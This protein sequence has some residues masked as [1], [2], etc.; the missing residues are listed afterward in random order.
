MSACSELGQSADRSS[1]RSHYAAST[2]HMHVRLSSRQ[3]LVLSLKPGWALVLNHSEACPCIHFLV[4][5]APRSCGRRTRCRKRLTYSSCRPTRQPSTPNSTNADLLSLRR[6]QW[7]FPLLDSLVRAS[8]SVN[9]FVGFMAVKRLNW[10]RC[11]Q[12]RSQTPRRRLCRAPSMN[13]VTPRHVAVPRRAL[14]SDRARRG[15]ST[16]ARRADAASHRKI[17]GDLQGEPRLP[18]DAR[19]ASPH[20]SLPAISCLGASRTPAARAYGWH[21]Y[22][23]VRE[24]CTGTDKW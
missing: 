19:S 21:L 4:R 1:P 2:M 10:F 11:R 9:C 6:E 18:V 5:A 20:V 12:L 17:G 24:T 13:L 23:G 22:P 16:K 7:A 14:S 3:G 8:Q 15:R